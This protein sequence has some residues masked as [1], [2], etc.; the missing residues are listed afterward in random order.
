MNQSEFNKTKTNMSQEDRCMNYVSLCAKKPSKVC[1]LS[2]KKL[3]YKKKMRLRQEKGN[4][5]LAIMNQMGIMNAQHVAD[6]M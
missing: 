1:R 5:V 2:R 6:N 3:K 4:E